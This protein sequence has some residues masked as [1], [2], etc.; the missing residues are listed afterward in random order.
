MALPTLYISHGSPM[1]AVLDTPAHRFLQ[2]LGKELPRPGAILMVSA[3]WE[4]LHHPAVSF[5]TQP[6]TIHDFGGFPRELYQIEYPAPGAPELA[7]KTAR[8]L[9]Q[10]GIPVAQD[11]S[12]GLDHG[13]WVPLQLMYPDA[14]IPVTQLSIVHN[15]GAEAHYRMGQ[16]LQSLRDQDVLIIA[17]GSL[18][19]NLGEF[20]GRSLDAP[21]PAWVSQFGDWMAEKLSTEDIAAVLDYRQRAPFAVKNHPSEDHLLPL[22]VA[23]GAAGEPLQPRRVHHS[24]EYGVLAMDT[25]AFG[26]EV[27]AAAHVA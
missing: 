22:F 17:S 15:W 11:P 20:F 6:D 2:A 9:D 13:A 12:R 19:H 10:A 21:A 27:P 5:S 18:T 26:T 24:L 3:H 4:T 25:Y 7:Q 23:M 8:L 1:T 16:A 14:D